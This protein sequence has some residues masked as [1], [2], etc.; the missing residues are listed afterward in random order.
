MN[1]M[2][3]IWSIGS[4]LENDGCKNKLINAANAK[5]L[6]ITCNSNKSCANA[7]I[8]CPNTDNNQC[9]ILCNG[10]N[11]CFQTQIYATESTKYLNI[12]CIESDACS[13]IE[14]NAL[15]T[16][17]INMQCI[18]SD[19]CDI[20]NIYANYTQLLTLTCEARNIDSINNIY[21]S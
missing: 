16:Y 4:R 13:Y 8:T 10:I 14:I 3:M 5:S 6:S 18:V 1:L 17:E 21:S 20:F 11:S 2:C 12:T 9:D 7:R 15:N 19:A